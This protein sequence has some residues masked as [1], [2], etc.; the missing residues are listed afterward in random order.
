MKHSTKKLSIILLLLF[1][2]LAISAQPA[3]DLICNAEAIPSSLGCTMGTNVASTSSGAP[4]LP[5][6]WGSVSN[7]VWFSFVATTATM[8]I[9]TDVTGL[10]LTDTQIALYSS[11][12]NTCTGTLTQVGCDDDAG[13]NGALLSVINMAGL[14]IGNTYFIR[15]DGFGT[16]TGTFCISAADTFVPGSTACSAQIV[17]PSSAACSIAAGNL[18]YNA[19]VPTAYYPALGVNYCGCDNE[20]VQRGTWSTFVANGTTATISNQTA[21][22]NAAPMDYTVFTGTCTSLTCVSCY[23][24]AKG[25]STPAIATV[26]GTTYFVLA[27][28]QGSDPTVAFRTDL[29]IQSNAACTVPVNNNCAGAI[30]ITANTAYT[31]SDNCA[32]AD[33]ALCAGSTENNI[34]YSWTTPGTWTGNAYFQLYNQNCNAGDV[35]SGSQVSIYSAGQTC[36]TTSTCAAVS[37]LGTDANI[38]I[39]WTPTAGSTYLITYDGFGGEVCSMNFIITNAPSLIPLPIELISF[40]AHKDDDAVQLKWT[41]ASEKNNDYFTVERTVDGISF[42]TIATVKGAGNSTKTLN[43]SDIDTKPYIGLAYYR[44]KQTDYDGKSSYSHLR[45]VEFI[46]EDLLSFE[47]IPNPAGQEDVF[48][49]FSGSAYSKINVDVY[50]ITGKKMFS[51]E[52][53]L[54][55]SGKVSLLINNNVILTSGI[56]LIKAVNDDNIITKKMIIK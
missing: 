36:A 18:A 35:S 55:N 9:S 23:S 28:L 54:P 43:Y 51:K 26:V 30:A 6:C 37:S 46:S 2:G 34:W 21:G 53:V 12:D 50:D 41:T 3:N 38:N 8:T 44:L 40:E 42:Q 16:A 22:A 10:T 17:N 31:A 29:C 52:I 4:A 5:S 20:A 39:M 19:T 56:Y 7:D 27:T 49:N 45:A 14:V 32:T 24:V 11:S 48:L 47:V 33:D 25:G 13:V 15:V 1:S